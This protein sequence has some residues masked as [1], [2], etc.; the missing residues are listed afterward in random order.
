MKTPAVVRHVH[1][2]IAIVQ[3]AN[4][5]FEKIQQTSDCSSF[6]VHLSCSAQLNK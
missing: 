5:L 6:F 2:L 1:A 3:H 4:V